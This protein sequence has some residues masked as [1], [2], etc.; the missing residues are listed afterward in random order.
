MVTLTFFEMNVPYSVN[1]FYKSKYCRQ[2]RGPF[3]YMYVVF[4]KSNKEIQQWILKIRQYAFKLRK[5]LHI[6]VIIAYCL[7]GSP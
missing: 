7:E 3:T 2:F 4:H 5:I 1:S 6:H